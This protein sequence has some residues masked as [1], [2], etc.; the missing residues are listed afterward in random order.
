MNQ[1]K[2]FTRLDS[3]GALRRCALALHAVAS[4]DREWLLAQLPAAQCTDLERL[5]RELQELGIPP[6]P[7]TALD[8]LDRGATIEASD[9]AAVLEDEP[10][11][12]IARA[13]ALHGASREAILAQLSANKR[14]LVQQWV[15]WAGSAPDDAP[16]PP[17]LALA[18]KDELAIR[19]K[20]RP[21]S[22]PAQR[23]SFFGKRWPEWTG[24]ARIKP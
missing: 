3:A 15:T 6:E 21:R 14:R 9:V 22:T 5:V 16:L 7:R 8:A 4:R 11:A 12:L 18:L 20:Q 23:C 2:D 17:A 24:L 10:P 19:L 1:S 13:L